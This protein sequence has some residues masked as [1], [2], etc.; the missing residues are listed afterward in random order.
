MRNGLGGA[1]DFVA[2]AAVAAAILAF[3]A[4]ERAGAHAD[5]KPAA[6]FASPAR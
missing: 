6:S 1:A 3:F 2:A 5:A 4:S